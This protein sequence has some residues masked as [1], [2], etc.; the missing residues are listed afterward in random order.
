MHWININKA[1]SSGF[2]DGVYTVFE[3]N[4]IVYRVCSSCRGF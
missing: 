4:R 1:P 3:N 2:D